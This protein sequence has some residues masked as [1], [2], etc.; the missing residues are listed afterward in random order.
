MWATKS[1]ECWLLRPKAEWQ[2]SSRDGVGGRCGIARDQVRLDQAVS[3]LTELSFLKCC[4]GMYSD[5]VDTV[6]AKVERASVRACECASVRERDW[7]EAGR[8]DG[9][10]LMWCVGNRPDRLPT[11]TRTAGGSHCTGKDH[12]SKR[13]VVGRYHVP[14]NMQVVIPNLFLSTNFNK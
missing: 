13:S 8:Y 11:Y 6:R 3:Y 4:Q 12:V 9:L 5:D 1:G 10:M 2:P 14:C 7:R